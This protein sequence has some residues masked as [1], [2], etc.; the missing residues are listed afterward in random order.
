MEIVVGK[1]GDYLDEDEGKGWRWYCHSC[2]GE[3]NEQTWDLS[4]IVA[5]YQE[6]LVSSHERTR[7]HFQG[8]SKF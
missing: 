2:G 7:T 6:H 1:K 5:S 8:W 3:Q 4:D